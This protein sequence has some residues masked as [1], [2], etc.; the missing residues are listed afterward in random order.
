MFPNIIEDVSARFG[1]PFLFTGAV[2]GKGEMT[3]TAL[4]MQSE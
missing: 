1:K 4:R 3:G 2:A